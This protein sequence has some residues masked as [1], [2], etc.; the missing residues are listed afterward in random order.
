MV[1]HYRLSMTSRDKRARKPRARITWLPVIVQ[2][3]RNTPYH[4]SSTT[5]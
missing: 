1:Y 2:N 4:T 3:N 5:K